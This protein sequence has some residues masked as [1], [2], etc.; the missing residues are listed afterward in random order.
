M[1]HYYEG[2]EFLPADFHDNVDYAAVIL[3]HAPCDRCPDAK[4]LLT[5][6]KHYYWWFPTPTN[7]TT[8]RYWPKLFWIEKPN[9]L[10]GILERFFGSG[11]QKLVFIET[12]DYKPH[13]GQPNN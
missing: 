1:K 8:I 12:T 11:A 2:S 7:S 13:R 6:G 9:T 4:Y 3:F 5:V 10:E